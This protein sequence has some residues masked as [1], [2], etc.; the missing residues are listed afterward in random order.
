[1]AKYLKPDLLIIDDMG[2]KQLPK[3][4]G[5]YLFEII[6]RRYENKRNRPTKYTRQ[7]GQ[8]DI[9]YIGGYA[10]RGFQLAGSS[11]SIRLAGW[12]LM[13]SRTSLT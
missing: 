11:S 2:I 5:E 1:M 9:E 6:M 8:G 7:K 3:R 4:S 10:W 12:V 13:R